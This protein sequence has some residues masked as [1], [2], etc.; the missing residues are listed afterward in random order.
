MMIQG[1]I[2]V[3]AIMIIATLMGVRFEAG[4]GRI[5]YILFLAML[6][7]GILSSLTLSLAASIKTMETLM[8]IV[9]LLTL[10]LI[11][12]SNALSP[13]AV[14]PGWPATIAR[15]NPVSYAV[16]PIRE[17]TISGWHWD[18]IL[19]GT[20]VIFGPV[21]AFML[22]SQL[23]FNVPRPS[24]GHDVPAADE[25]TP[26]FSCRYRYEV[27]RRVHTTKEERE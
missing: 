4:F 7:S 3:I 19:P 18:K 17:F 6:F 12:T 2:Q 24:R 1:A 20:L 5:V 26:V 10:P 16:G 27:L 23:V 21:V 14:M 8:A 11:F 15:I 13:T 9:N 25:T 22:G